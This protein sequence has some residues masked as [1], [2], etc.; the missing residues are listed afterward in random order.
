MPDAHVNQVPMLR[1]CIPG[2]H[3]KGVHIRCLC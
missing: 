3:V 2:A 1:V